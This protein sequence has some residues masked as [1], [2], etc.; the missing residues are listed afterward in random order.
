VSFHVGLELAVLSLAWYASAAL[1]RIKWWLIPVISFASVA[2]LLPGNQFWVLVTVTPVAAILG[3]G[4]SRS[5][6][7]TWAS[8]LYIVA[9]LSAVMTG[10]VGYLNPTQ[11][12]ATSWILVGFGLLSYTIGLLEGLE[13]CLWLLPA[14]TTWALLDAAQLGD[15]YRPL[16]IALLYAVVGV[17]IGL[18]HSVILPILGSAKKKN[19]LKYV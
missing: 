11:L 1:S 16:V 18:L 8:P 10:V 9:L 4:V 7:R 17:A 14:F 3:F 13:P 15:L 5:F 12:L 2:L 6:D 19:L